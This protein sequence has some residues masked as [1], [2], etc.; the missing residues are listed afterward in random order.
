MVI[1]K[2]NTFDTTTFKEITKVF[3]N[4]ANLLIYLF[5]VSCQFYVDTKLYLI[6]YCTI[7]YH[8]SYL[9]SE[10]YLR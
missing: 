1:L 7:F 5:I 10:E 8:P 6:F 4:M 2:V 9:I 3:T